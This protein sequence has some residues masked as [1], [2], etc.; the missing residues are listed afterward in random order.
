[1]WPQH[2]QEDKHV[3]AC[4]FHPYIFINRAC[5]EILFLTQE[6]GKVLSVINLSVQGDFFQAFVKCLK[7]ESQQV[8]GISGLMGIDISGP[9]SSGYLRVI[10]H[11]QVP[12]LVIGI[13]CSVV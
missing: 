10:V 3:C 6:L 7:I 5:E 4:S 12:H 13:C 8:S 9:L 2:G 11:A 1:M